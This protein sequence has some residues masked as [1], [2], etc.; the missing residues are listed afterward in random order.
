M[1]GNLHLFLWSTEYPWLIRNH[2]ELIAGV[3]TELGNHA[4]FVIDMVTG[5]VQLAK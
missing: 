3:V 1:L 5:V 4:Q 2:R